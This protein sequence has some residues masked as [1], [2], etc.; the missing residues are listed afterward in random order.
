[1]TTIQLIQFTEQ[2]DT[3]HGAGIPYLEYAKVLDMNSEIEV[4][5]DDA[6]RIRDRHRN[7]RRIQKDDNTIYNLI[8]IT[9]EDDSRLF[10]GR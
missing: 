6:I 3:R 5:D 7:T 9:L 10:Q 8:T 2:V 1:M 4:E